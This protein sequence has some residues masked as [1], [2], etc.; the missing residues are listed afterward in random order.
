MPRTQ[1]QTLSTKFPIKSSH[2][3]NSSEVGWQLGTCLAKQQN[4]KLSKSRTWI[5]SSGLL[6]TWLSN[7]RKGFPLRSLKNEIFFTSRTPLSR[8]V[9]FNFLNVPPL[10]PSPLSPFIIFA[11]RSRRVPLYGRMRTERVTETRQRLKKKKNRQKLM[12]NLNIDYLNEAERHY[13]RARY[14]FD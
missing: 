2:T 6:N 3:E 1:M 12:R 13:G 11:N 9:R 4:L 7:F 8:P 5:D 14:I 10:P